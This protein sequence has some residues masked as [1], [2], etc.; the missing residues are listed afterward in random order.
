MAFRTHEGT[1][2]SSDPTTFQP[3]A[4]ASMAA[5][6]KPPRGAHSSPTHRA[7]L[8]DVQ[9][10]TWPVVRGLQ[11]AR[12]APRVACSPCA[13]LEVSSPGQS[14]NASTSG[15][16]TPPASKTTAGLAALS[17]VPW[18]ARIHHYPRPPVG[19]SK[20]HPPIGMNPVNAAQGTCHMVHVSPRRP[21]MRDF[22]FVRPAREFER[23]RLPHGPRPASTPRP[24]LRNC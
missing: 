15:S 10:S 7:R 23:Q 1:A 11:R 2:S 18:P 13:L 4:P 22:H 12:L 19:A 8:R 17:R 21:K 5:L 9:T 24:W 16:P 6:P 20:L 3:Q 14:R